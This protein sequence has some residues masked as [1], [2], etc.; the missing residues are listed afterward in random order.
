M[1][2][3]AMGLGTK[4]AP[5]GANLDPAE[6]FWSFLSLVPTISGKKPGIISGLKLKPA[7]GLGLLVKIGGDADTTDAGI[8]QIGRRYVLVSNIGE[9]TVVSLP[10]ASDTGAFAAAV[11]VYVD[12]SNTDAANEKPG[13]P[14]YV[15]T[16]VVKGAVGSPDA[17]EDENAAR[18]KIESALPSGAAGAY[19]YL[20]WVKIDVNASSVGGDDCHPADTHLPTPMARQQEIQEKVG[21]LS[22]TLLEKISAVNSKLD[23]LKDVGKTAVLNR[24]EQIIYTGTNDWSVNALPNFE[25][26]AQDFVSTD[27]YRITIHRKGTYM[28]TVDVQMSNGGRDIAWRLARGNDHWWMNIARSMDGRLSCARG[29]AI[30]KITQPEDFQ[31]MVTNWSNDNVKMAFMRLTLVCI[32]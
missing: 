13:T 25:G 12:T 32:K 22:T 29:T 14:D 8:I 20:G 28:I 5:A 2:L 30:V 15:K 26:D 27:D 4:E 7:N 23:E 3:V 17:F 10:K 11:A 19:L 21:Q 1:G 18:T 24:G 31:V 6:S 9:P 16:L